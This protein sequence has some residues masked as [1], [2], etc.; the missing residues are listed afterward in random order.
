M[1]SPGWAGAPISLEPPVLLG[2]SCARK[3]EDGTTGHGGLPNLIC[4]GG[5][6]SP[7][8]S[9][10]RKTEGFSEAASDVS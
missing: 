9:S 4:R 8:Q 1:L 10:A 6:R 7:L 3:G 5:K 2:V